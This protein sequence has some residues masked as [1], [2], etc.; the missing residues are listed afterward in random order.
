MVGFS[1][2]REGGREGVKASGEVGREGGGD[3]GDVVQRMALV[4]RVVGGRSL[5]KGG[6]PRRD[7]SCGR[8]M[9]QRSGQ[10][11]EWNGAWLWGGE[12]MGVWER[13]GSESGRGRGWTVVE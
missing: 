13:E 3:L 6:N 11:G 1:V 4:G 10:E 5:Q 9:V 8:K 12:A 7:Q 2:V